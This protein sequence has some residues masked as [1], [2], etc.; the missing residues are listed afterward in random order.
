MKT[1]VFAALGLSMAT[2]HSATLT[3][4]DVSRLGPGVEIHVSG[5]PGAAVVFDGW[6]GDSGP[7][8]GAWYALENEP[9]VLDGNGEGVY[10]QQQGLGNMTAFRAKTTNAVPTYSAN[11]FGFTLINMPAGTGGYSN[12]FSG[13]TVSNIKQYAS[14]FPNPANGTIVYKFTG[15]ASSSTFSSGSWSNPSLAFDAGEGAIIYSPSAQSLVSKG[16]IATNT[17]QSL[18]SPT[19]TLVGPL[20]FGNTPNTSF[21]FTWTDLACGAAPIGVQGAIVGFINTDGTT[22]VVFK[23]SSSTVSLVHAGAVW[24]KPLQ[25]HSRDLLRSIW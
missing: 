17:S 20:S 23:S 18:P 8:S 15:G 14:G 19:Y 7:V 21:N 13:W 25:T 24:V 10:T 22:N 16:S 11:G 12:P 2:L 3:I 6:G 1:L 4:T 5:S 9:L